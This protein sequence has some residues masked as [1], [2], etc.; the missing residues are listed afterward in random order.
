MKRW[1]LIGMLLALCLTVSASAAL[2]Q[3][4]QINPQ[5]KPHVFTV[6][7]EFRNV[8]FSVEDPHAYFSDLLNKRVNAYFSDNSGG[9]FSPVFDVYGPVLLDE[10]MATYGKDVIVAGERIGDEAPELSLLDACSLLDARV[11]FARY[12]ADGDG[13][14]DMVLFYFAGYDQAEGGLSD[15]IWSHH[16][17]IQDKPLYAGFSLDGVRFGYYFCTSEL[18][19]YEGTQPI[20][21]GTTV[22][23][24]GHALGLPDFYDT[25]GGQDGKAG[26]LYQFSPMAEGL[27]NNDGDTPPYL[28]AL[29]RILLGWMDEEDLLDLQEGWMRLP[30]VQSG[31]AAISRTATE[32]EY[33]LYEFRN[34]Q[35]WDDPLPAGLVAY[36]VDRSHRQL[37][38]IPIITLW[39]EWRKYNNLNANGK[40]PCFYVVPPLDPGN[41]NYAGAVNPGTLVFPG[42]GHVHCFEPTDW[43]NAQTGIQ[44]TCVDSDRS[45]ARFLALK[46]QGPMVSGMVLDAGNA[47]LAGVTL[48]LI[49]DGEVVASDRSGMDGFF[50]LPVKG[51]TDASFLLT[52]EMPGYR[53]VSESVILGKAGLECRYLQLFANEAPASVRLYKYNPAASPGFYPTKDAVTGAV[54]FSADDLAPYVGGRLTHVTCYPF[55]TDPAGAGLM[56][57]MVDIGGKRVLN[58]LVSR[59]ELGEYLPVGVDITDADLRIPAGVDIYIGYGFQR[60]GTNNPIATV[61]PGSAGNSYYAPFS[62][63]TQSWKPLYVDEAGFYMDI[64]LDAEVNEISASSLAQMGFSCIQLNKERYKA[65]DSL[66]MQL[67]VPAWEQVDQCSWFLDGAPQSADTITLT[68]GMHTLEAHVRYRDGRE[69]SLGTEFRVY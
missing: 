29:E 7:V 24:M 45:S 9:L 47:P 10:P 55:I 25:N 61:Y 56:Y 30:P 53:S 2:A 8:R 32:G 34:G 35:G 51:N 33:F 46:R 19:G 14:I 1:L 38:G 60:Q 20:G 57:V 21:I 11:D 68:S 43:N 37:N 65:G 49:R 28:N 66:S 16:Q 23:E 27:Y 62:M 58:Q 63:N 15:A 5:G 36:H 13:I 42:T 3:H 64:M 41:L 17:D 22:H 4:R 44:I 6:L 31:A 26:G 59:P 18:R 39:N 54:R 12:D 52:A 50:L 67:L 40:H 48:R 69:E